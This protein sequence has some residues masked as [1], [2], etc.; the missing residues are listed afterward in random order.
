MAVE[1]EKKR[2]K[3]EKKKRKREAFTFA[4]SKFCHLF[5][6]L[7]TFSSYSVVMANTL[8]WVFFLFKKMQ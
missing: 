1:E 6:Q 4:I 7:V 5:P 2:E 8:S 3:R